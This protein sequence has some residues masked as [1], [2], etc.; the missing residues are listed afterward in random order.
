MGYSIFA[1]G[2]SDG[3]A[4]IGLDDP[5]CLNAP[6][7]VPYAQLEQVFLALG[8]HSNRYAV[9]LCGN[10]WGACSGGS[11]HDLIAKLLAMSAMQLAIAGKPIDT[12]A[13]F[14]TNFV[15]AVVVHEPLVDGETALVRPRA[16]AVK[17]AERAAL[18]QSADFTDG[19]RTFIEKHLA[20]F[21]L[22]EQ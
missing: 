4:T 10:D 22:R 1:D 20:N 19:Y 5:D 11:M 2:I 3:S 16:L 6:A 8:S 14:L 17:A 18:M 15:N 7:S 21:S 9:V 12:A 13:A